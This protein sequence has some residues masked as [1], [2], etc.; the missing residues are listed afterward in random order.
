MH[1][2]VTAGG[3][4]EWIDS[5]R[6]ITNLS[7]GR[8][9]SM[10]ADRFTMAS[11]VSR[12]SFV[13]SKRSY[14][15]LKSDK[16]KRYFADTHQ[17]VQ[18]VI[19]DIIQN[20]P[21]DVIIHSMAVSDYHVQS[22]VSLET[23]A[24]SLAQWLS[25]LSRV[26]TAEEIAGFIH[27]YPTVDTSTKVSSRIHHPLLLLAPNSKIIHSLR[28]LAPHAVIVGFKLAHTDSV[29]E[30]F[31]IAHRLL[32]D[33]HCDFVLANQVQ[34]VNDTSHRAYLL[35][36]SKNYHLWSSKEAIAYGIVEEVLKLKKER[37]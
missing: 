34:E 32:V 25:A 27:D 31:E 14:Q 37:G 18:T 24:Q 12:V 20:D 36:S 3:T 17:E 4:S 33:N 11:E 23:V 35:D 29:D 5:V 10:I 26:P 16:I 15:P 8:L 19:E 22:L 30:L 28:S 13:A 1:I 2:L 9:G 21:P 6:V 7:T